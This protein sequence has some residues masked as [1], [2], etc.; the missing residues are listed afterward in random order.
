M[1]FIFS[2]QQIM[3]NFSKLLLVVSLGFGLMGSTMAATSPSLGT[4]ATF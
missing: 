2:L 1:C 3:K 4:A